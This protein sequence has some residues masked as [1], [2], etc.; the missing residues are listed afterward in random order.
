MASDA[1]KEGVVDISTIWTD[2]GSKPPD[3]YKQISH[4]PLGMEVLAI[5]L[6]LSLSLSLFLFLFHVY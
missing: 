3:M 1:S 5:S 4:T 2:K 6:S